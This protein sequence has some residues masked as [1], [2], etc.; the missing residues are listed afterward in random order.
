M[1]PCELWSPSLHLNILLLSLY[2]TNSCLF[3]Y[4]EQDL[5]N[6]PI[7]L[8]STFIYVKTF[9]SCDF[10]AT[11]LISPDHTRISSTTV[12]KSV[13]GSSEEKHRVTLFPSS[14]IS[15]FMTS[16]ITLIPMGEPEVD[17]NAIKCLSSTRLIKLLK[18]RQSY[19]PH[20]IGRHAII[21]NFFL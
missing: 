15:T 19:I 9:V 11:F 12:K 8:C 13:M 16:P 21:N 17:S 20:A 2:E 5:Q 6:P 3:L 1:G 4:P 18:K 7:L 10:L 14:T